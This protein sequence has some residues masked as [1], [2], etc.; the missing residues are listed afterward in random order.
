MKTITFGTGQSNF[1][2]VLLFFICFL[3]SFN[4]Q[5]QKIQTSL[6]ETWKNGAW[7][8]LT[9]T[10]NTYDG[11]GYLIHDLTQDWN[12][13]W[14]DKLQNNYTNNPDGT[15]QQSISQLWYTAANGW[16]NLQRMTYTYT[17]AKKVL[18][19][20]SEGWDDSVNI[21]GEWTFFLKQ[22]NTYDG[23]NYLIKNLNE[24]WYNNS[25]WEN[26]SQTTF[27][28]NLDGT[29]HEAISET[30]NPWGYGDNWYYTY[31]ITYTYD[32]SK[33]TTAVTEKW[34][35]IGSIWEKFSKQTYGYDGSGYLINILSENWLS[36]WDDWIHDSQ[37][38]IVN[39]GNGTPFQI[40]S[41]DWDGTIP[42]WKN[43]SRTTLTYTSLAV[44]E[45]IFGKSFAVYPNPA[46][47]NVTIK[48]N[49]NNLGVKYWVTDQLGRQF[50]NGTI[51][52][53]A[54]LIDVSQWASGVYFVQ[55]GQNKNQTIKMVK[56]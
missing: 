1:G 29:V 50:L 54:T 37:S 43:E 55:I 41:Q 24:W 45:N 3:S 35:D 5:S 8:N 9:Q 53:T 22:T 4:S 21:F 34:N 46:Q 2:T 28:N 49:E 44:Q 38:L 14:K 26:V 32:N 7:E 39:Y 11:N 17:A 36:A 42:A 10:L 31:R 20:E 25:Q 51:T 56:K 23:N 12:V 15:V 27:T 18:T 19:L 6:V 16:G 33:L 52:D 48:T 13:S 30:W 40:V 47:D